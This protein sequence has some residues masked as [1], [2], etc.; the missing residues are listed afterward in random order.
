MSE[1]MW[2]SYFFEVAHDGWPSCQGPGGNGPGPFKGGLSI[3]QLTWVV[4]CRISGQLWVDDGLVSK[5]P[6]VIRISW[7]KYAHINQIISLSPCH[8]MKRFQNKMLLDL[9]AETHPAIIRTAACQWKTCTI[10]YEQKQIM[11]FL[12]GIDLNENG[13]FQVFVEMDPPNSLTV[14]MGEIGTGLDSRATRVRS[15]FCAL[16]RGRYMSASLSGID[17]C[18]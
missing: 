18:I 17:M 9:K 7:L 5:E 15:K 14:F 3:C 2:K 12:S 4:V 10:H 13:W 11:I 1:W 8:F 16:H 6:F